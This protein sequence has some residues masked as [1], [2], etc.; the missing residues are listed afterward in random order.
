M[1]LKT[2]WLQPSTYNAVDDRRAIGNILTPI[3]GSLT[4]TGY[5]IGGFGVTQ[6]AT[7]GWNVEVAAGRAI[8]PTPVADGGAYS[9]LNESKVTLAIQPATAQ[10]RIDLVVLRVA[11]ADYA[12]GSSIAVLE[13]VTGTP[14]AS[15]VPPAITTVGALQLAR[16]NVGANVASI[17]N[18][19]INP[20][21]RIGM[22]SGVLSTTSN[23]R[24]TNVPN[25]FHIFE[26]DTNRTLVRDSSTPFD[27]GW[28]SLGWSGSGSGQS[29]PRMWWAD[30]GVNDAAAQNSWAYF[31]GIN[32]LS[33][34]IPAWTTFLVIGH[35]RF[36][37]HVNNSN[38]Y[39]ELTWQRAGDGTQNALTST[40]ATEPAVFTHRTVLGI[41]CFSGPLDGWAFNLRGLCVESGIN[42]YGGSR[43]MA[44]RLS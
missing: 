43:I 16:I 40:L 17:T 15:P 3:P 21:T 34:P 42:V 8:L 39:I 22:P 11:D 29:L 7:P 26:T 5:I 36:N 31:C 27:G 2:L 4:G 19:Y 33:Y 35:A 6:T 32:S 37:P 41:A 9:V 28:Q 30:R 24:P 13:V 20:T 1:A 25:G 23:D 18:T 38:V 44:Y 10:P 14:A 12:G